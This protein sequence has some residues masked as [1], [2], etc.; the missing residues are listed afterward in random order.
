MKV[1]WKDSEHH[2]WTR[3]W[4]A[5][6]HV[7]RM[8]EKEI[9]KRKYTN[10]LLIINLINVWTVNKTNE[11]IWREEKRKFEKENE[12]KKEIRGIQNNSE[13]FEWKGTYCETFISENWIYLKK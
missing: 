8:T 10:Y 12:W 7:R 1:S 4:G 3:Q 13:N 2:V 11:M 6:H 9:E 5:N